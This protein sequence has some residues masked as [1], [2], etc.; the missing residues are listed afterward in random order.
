MKDIKWMAK[1]S[2]AASKIPIAIMNGEGLYG[3]LRETSELIKAWMDELDKASLELFNAQY[4]NKGE[5]NDKD[6]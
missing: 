2:E 4:K 5:E 6:S 3:A 1:F